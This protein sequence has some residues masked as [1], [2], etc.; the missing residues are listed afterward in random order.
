MQIENKVLASQP[1]A[2]PALLGSYRW[3]GIAIRI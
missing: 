2:M 3:N 1:V